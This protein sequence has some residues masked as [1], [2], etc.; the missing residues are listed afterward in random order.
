MS[1][2]VQLTELVE[3]LR[4]IPTLSLVVQKVM[5]LVNNP[6]TSAPQIADVLKKDQVL[7]AKVLRLVNSSFYNLSTEVTDVSRALAFLGFNSISMLVLGTSVFSAFQIRKAPYFNVLEFWRHSLGTAI[8][9]EM[10]A[11]ELKIKKPE[12]A[13]SCGLLHDVGK[14]A[15][16]T[17]D[18][19]LLQRIVDKAKTDQ[20][21]FS[22][23]EV[24]LEIPS[25][26]VLGER[27]AQRWQLPLIIQKA[28]RYH[29]RDIEPMESIYPQYKSTLMVAT[30]GNVMA[31]R[32]QVGESGDLVKPDYPENYLLALGVSSEMLAKIEARFPTEMERA[33][34]FLTASL[35]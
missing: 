15:L 31:K 12:E 22:D 30:L 6:K 18:P 32:F 19:E 4:D 20:I 7:T 35:S 9:A 17:I 3:K 13:F 27:L 24:E 2:S 11:R 33:S 26:T 1:S 10:I 23:A 34:S 28:I 29:H 14:I 25:H 16:F 5:E 8:A 21:S